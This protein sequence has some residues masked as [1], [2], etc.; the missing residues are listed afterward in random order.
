MYQMSLNKPSGLI[1]YIFN[2]LLFLEGKGFIETC[3]ISPTNNHFALGNCFVGPR[4]LAPGGLFCGLFEF[5]LSPVT[6]SHSTND[7]RGEV[8]KREIK[9]KN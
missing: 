3:E 8:E 2:F 1:T 4:K 6:N 9:K 7:I 5:L